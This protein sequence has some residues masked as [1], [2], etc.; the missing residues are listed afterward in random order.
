MGHSPTLVRTAGATLALLCLSAVSSAQERTNYFELKRIADEA[1]REFANQ[2]LHATLQAKK[3]KLPIRVNQ[4]NGTTYELMRF[5]DGHPVY[6][7]THNLNAAI[8]TR[9]N[10]V[11]VGGGAGLN[12]SGSGVLLGIWDGG[13]ARPSHQEFNGRV[14]VQDGGSMGWH[15]TH[16]AG[17]MIA[18]GVDPD[19]IGASFFATL[20]S[21]D[22]DDDESEM[23]D[24]AAANL[25]I[26]NHSYGVIS[27]W[28]HNGADW[29]WYGNPAVNNQEAFQ[30]GFYSQQAHDWDEICFNAPFYLPVKSAGNDRGEGPDADDQPTGYYWNGSEWTP[31]TVVRNLDGN[32][33]GYDTI[34]GSGISKNTF[35][36]GAVDDVLNY[37]GP[38]SVAMSS[39]SCWGPTDDGRIKPDVVANGVALLSS[40]SSNDSSYVI[41]SG[42]SMSTPNVSGSLGLLVE[43]HRDL[44]AGADMRAATLKGLVIHTADECG[45]NDGPDYSYGWGLMDTEAAA[46]VITEADAWGDALQERTLADGATFEKDYYSDG[47]EP[48]RLTISWT[49]PAGPVSSAAL[50]SRTAKLVNDLDIRIESN[51]TTYSPWVLNPDTPA[52]AATTGDNT[53]DNVEQIV[54]AAPAAGDYTITVSHKGSLQGGSQAYSLILSGLQ[55]AEATITSVTLPSDTFSWTGTAV[56]TINLN[57]PAQSG[58]VTVNPRTSSLLN[59]PASVV[60]PE[61]ASSA[62]FNVT[63]KVQNPTYTWSTTLIVD[64]AALNVSTPIK[65]APVKLVGT[66]LNGSV[67][68]G[69]NATLTLTLNGPA[70]TG[71][72]LISLDG[73]H[74]PAFIN[75]PPAAIIP[76]GQTTLNVTLT[77]SAPASSFNARVTARHRFSGTITYVFHKLIQINP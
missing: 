39:F 35:T 5:E 29:Y 47:T 70:P 16:V 21:Y 61:G 11:W 4:P 52:A 17:T 32:S 63:S 67:T 57:R 73:S 14:T 30:F 77:T 56:A 60:I 38:G 50:N 36:V 20:N 3:L 55:E 41:S 58:G 66:T 59:V 34:A 62:N 74:K 2:K 76:A 45:P 43:H 68:G 7:I 42:T 44:F 54:I 31:N 37:T 49:D 33:T 75:Y 1:R 26:S 6:Y 71:G 46:A 8:T 51:G 48:I 18:A 13:T 15:A 9:A 65:I 12:L 23:A 22:W 64:Q 25:R 40:N 10:R 28:Y 53:R 72:L 27:G 24:A 19:A 69:S